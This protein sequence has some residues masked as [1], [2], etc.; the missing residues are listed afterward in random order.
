MGWRH[1]PASDHRTCQLLGTSPWFEDN[2]MECNSRGMDCQ[3]VGIPV[4]YLAAR[5]GAL[6]ALQYLTTHVRALPIGSRMRAIVPP[7]DH[8]ATIGAIKPRSGGSASKQS[9][10]VGAMG[11]I[12]L[13]HVACAYGE[14]EVLQWALNHS[15]T[16][17]DELTV[18][19]A[20]D[21]NG[22]DLLLKDPRGLLAIHYCA[23]ES[24]DPRLLGALLS[25]AVGS[26]QR[27]AQLSECDLRLVVVSISCCV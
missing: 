14:L 15:S 7:Q 1:G 9:V 22:L 5:Y 20:E 13:A 2:G 25:E 19:N 6:E 16:L 4:L 3:A 10:A 18:P 26:G 8:A 21:A 27:I 23:K 11:W 12:N 24:D 17:G